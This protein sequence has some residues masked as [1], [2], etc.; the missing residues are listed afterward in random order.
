MVDG[1]AAKGG[2]ETI[3]VSNLANCHIIQLYNVMLGIHC[4]N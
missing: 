2:Q 1:A 3:R 4:L